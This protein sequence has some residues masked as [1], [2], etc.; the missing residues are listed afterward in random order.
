[1]SKVTDV[2]AFLAEDPKTF[3]CGRVDKGKGKFRWT[4]TI[5]LDELTT[6]LAADYPE[7]GRV[8]NLIPKT[9]G[10]SGRIQTVT[11]VG[12]K[13]SVDISG[14]LNSR[15]TLGGLK[16]TLFE[17]TREGEKLVFRG[18]GFG[19]GV[20]MCQLGAIGMADA[21]KSHKDILGHYYRGTHIHKLY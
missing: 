9:R 14:D 7:I 12:D 21:G 20:G 2:G 16:S 19:H 11:I 5:P 3:W 17:V 10:V 18:A 15:R 13:R 6:R 4:E 1:M 8:K